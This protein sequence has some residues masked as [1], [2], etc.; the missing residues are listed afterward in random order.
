MKNV[1][2]DE[3]TIASMMPIIRI[4]YCFRLCFRLPIARVLIVS[5]LFIAV[6]LPELYRGCR[7]GVFDYLAV[8]NGKNSLRL[9]CNVQ[10]VGYKNKGN[11]KLFADIFKQ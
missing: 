3:K 8:L 5:F 9:L 6:H 10:V 1:I 2:P 11:A 4:A 7:L